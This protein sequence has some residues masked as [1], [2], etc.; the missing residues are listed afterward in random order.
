[1]ET[2]LAA[3]AAGVVTEVRAATGTQVAPGDCLVVLG[4]LS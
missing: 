2:Y 3:P 4:P 1:M